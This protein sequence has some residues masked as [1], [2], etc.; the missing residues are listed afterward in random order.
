MEKR[1]IKWGEGTQSAI[2]ALESN[3][4]GCEIK[5]SWRNA[6]SFGDCLGMH[7]TDSEGI[8]YYAL[9]SL[10]IFQD[11]QEKSKI[12]LFIKH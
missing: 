7:F 3:F 2:D 11:G 4:K 12:Q 1:E 8:K 9:G 5:F 10:T 6:Y